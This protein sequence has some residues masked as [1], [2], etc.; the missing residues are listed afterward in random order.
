MNLYEPSTLS[1]HRV[2][3][4]HPV[5]EVGADRRGRDEEAEEAE[6]GEREEEGRRGQ[7]RRVSAQ[8]EHSEVR[9]MWLQGVPESDKSCCKIDKLSSSQ[10]HL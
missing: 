5:R 8:T 7:G 10:H 4:V 3:G 1:H 9:S 2:Q 6:G